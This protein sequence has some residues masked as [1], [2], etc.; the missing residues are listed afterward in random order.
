MAE[1]QLVVATSS[2][3]VATSFGD[4]CVAANSEQLH[5]Q[6]LEEREKHHHK[7]LWTKDSHGGPYRKVSI[8]TTSREPLKKGYIRS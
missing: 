2:Q 7:Q 5:Q 3:A 8:S 1:R 4:R 6:R